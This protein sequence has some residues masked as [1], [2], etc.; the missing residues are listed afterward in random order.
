MRLI[1]AE[2]ML[3]HPQD[4][5]ARVVRRDVPVTPRG[6]SETLGP[7]FTPERRRVW[8]DVFEAVET[9]PSSISAG[10]GPFVVFTDAIASTET[11]TY[12]VPAGGV[13]I[14]VSS[15]V[16][17]LPSPSFI[18]LRVTGGRLTFASPPASTSPSDVT[19][20]AATTFT[21]E[22]DIDAPATPLFFS[23]PATVRL[24]FNGDTV[25]AMRAAKA[26]LSVNGAVVDLDPEGPA[27]LAADGHRLQF[28]GDA[29]TIADT[30]SSAEQSIQLSGTWTIDEA[31]WSFN[32][33]TLDP[34]HPT[35]PNESGFGALDARAGLRLSWYGVSAPIPI[36]GATVLA[37]ADHFEITARSTARGIRQILHDSNQVLADIRFDPSAPIVT[38]Q[39]RAGLGGVAIDHTRDGARHTEA[40]ADGGW[41]ADRDHCR[42][43]VLRPHRIG[44]SGPP[45]CR[46]DT[47]AHADGAGAVECSVD[48]RGPAGSGSPVHAGRRQRR[49]LG[50]AVVRLRVERRPP[51]PAG[52]C[53]SR[54]SRRH[55]NDRAKTRT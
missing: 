47:A 41:V 53:T 44:G 3:A 8:F 43:G 13:W 6:A 11:L 52:S 27:T 10:A 29:T 17:G 15:L 18:G 54:T 12:S 35:L 49:D 7:F 24:D 36:E 42:R 4:G 45:R 48:G 2:E 1:A 20:G 16:G 22:L 28:G 39:V 55:H 46:H 37:H 26:R 50:P 51:D 9:T 5:P 32:P 23:P 34:Q 31:R 40:T 30:A 25:T 38:H 14:R 19:V 21:V 33:E